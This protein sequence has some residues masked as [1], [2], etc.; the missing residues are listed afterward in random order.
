[1]RWAWVLWG[2]MLITALTQILV[3]HQQR[4]LLKEWQQQDARRVQL[5][6]EYS[7][8]LLERGTL[9]A[10][11]R[12]DQLARQQLGMTEPTEVQVLKP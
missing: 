11:N 2:L 9:S 1:M 5:Q 7:K 6:Q 8:L 12:L 4:Q 10:H 3:S